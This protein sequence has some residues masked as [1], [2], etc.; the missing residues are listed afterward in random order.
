ME[1]NQLK[2]EYGPWAK[3]TA[4]ICSD[5]KNEQEHYE[6]RFLE[7]ADKSTLRP[8]KGAHLVLTPD[9]LAWM[10]DILEH[11]QECYPTA[12]ELDA[13]DGVM[14]RKECKDI[15]RQVKNNMNGWEAV[16]DNF[17][18]KVF[19]SY[20]WQEGEYR[21]TVI[22]GKPKNGETDDSNAELKLDVR[23]WFQGF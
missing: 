22:L 5:K 16:T 4:A 14:T 18:H 20:P 10:N 17:G 2:A 3:L 8:G 9:L 19:A 12:E 21:I 6:K 15:L 7:M 13:Q 11:V 1:R 23:Y